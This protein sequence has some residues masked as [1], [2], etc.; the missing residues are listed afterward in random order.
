MIEDLI[1]DSKDDLVKI[2]H[3]EEQDNLCV[4]NSI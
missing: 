2:R 1:Y 3:S 4:R